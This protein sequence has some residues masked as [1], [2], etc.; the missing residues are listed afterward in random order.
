[1]ITL[2]SHLRAP[3]PVKL[4]S[5]VRYMHLSFSMPIKLASEADTTKITVQQRF[6]ISNTYDSSFVLSTLNGRQAPF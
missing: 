4:N 1:M 2:S 6:A 3:D 5:N